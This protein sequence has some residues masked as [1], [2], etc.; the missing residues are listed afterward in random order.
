M[1]VV[2]VG[3][4]GQRLDLDRGLQ[5]GAAGR[6]AAWPWSF[7]LGLAM[8]GPLFS[9]SAWNN[10][11][12]TG[13]E[14][15][16]PGRTLP[17]ALFL[18]CGE[19]RRALPA[20]QPGLPRHAAA[21]P[22]SSTPRRTGSA[23]RRWRRSSARPGTIVMAVAILIST[24]GCVNGLV[25]A[26]ARVYYAMARDGLFFARRRAPPTAATSRPSPWWRRGSGPPC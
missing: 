13:G 25:L 19:R 17:A 16:D 21:R 3:P 9:Q 23:P 6:R 12:F 20:G 8:I 22:R 2:V 15:R 24:F 7:L 4:L 1:D 14:T 5:P 11:T 26:G 10:V 18:G